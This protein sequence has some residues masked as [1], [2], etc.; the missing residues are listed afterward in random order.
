[1]AQSL[2]TK[3][4]EFDFIKGDF[5]AEDAQE[6]IRHLFTKK[7]SFHELKSFSAQIQFGKSDQ[8]SLDRIKILKN[9][10]SAI[11]KEILIAKEQSKTVR[12]SSKIY[13]ELI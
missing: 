4:E 1:M 8:D 10:M 6:I 13:I 5:A 12:L 7:I 2:T 9:R 11:E 3:K